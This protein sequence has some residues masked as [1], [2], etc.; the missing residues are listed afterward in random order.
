MNSL[1]FYPEK[2]NLKREEKKARLDVTVFSIV[3]FIATLM[4]VFENSFAP[5][6][7]LVLILFVHEFG[8]FVLMKRFNYQ[9]V[10][11]LFVPLLGAFVQGN[12]D[13]YSQ[14]EA[15]LVVLGGPI[16]GLLLGTG[17]F[18]FG[19]NFQEPYVLTL[20]FIFLLLNAFNL[21]PLDPLDGGQLLNL[22]IGKKQ[23]LFQMGFSI[24][25][26][27]I[28]LGLGLYFE[29]IVLSVLGLILTLRIWKFLKKY[30]LQKSFRKA[31]IQFH[32]TYSDLSNK[33]Y[34]EI[35]A[36]LL[37]SNKALSK[38]KEMN[39]NSEETEE[40]IA[41]QVDAALEPLLAIDAKWSLKI[42]ILILWILGLLCPII[43]LITNESKLN[44][45]GVFVQSWR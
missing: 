22:L 16:P 45:Y 26:S 12:K 5:I 9:N 33:E 27:V 6:M 23:V 11:M 20:A 39:D 38:Y 29:Q 41:L 3:L 42:G 2:P 40:V 44:W 30:N 4:L 24:F 21:L 15:L 19:I 8:H 43:L 31:N 1:D 35:R 17:L 14:I 34:A 25:T 32:N 18:Y 36:I 37:D 13:R 7:A 10:R 28:L